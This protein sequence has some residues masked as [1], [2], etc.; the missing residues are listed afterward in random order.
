MS[1][2]GNTEARELNLIGKVELKIALVDSDEAL[3]AILKTYLPP[4]LLKLASDSVAV[5]NK[6]RLELLPAILKGLH[7]NYHES[8][9]HAATLFNLFLKLLHSISLPSRGDNE[10]SALRGR[11]GFSE[12]P[13]D[14]SFLADWSGKLVLFSPGKPPSTRGPGLTEDDYNFLQLY[15][16][17]DTWNPG[18]SDGMN[19]SETKVVCIRFVASGAFTDQERFLP[20]LFASA[21]TNSRISDVGNDMLKR[22]TSAISLEDMTLIRNLYNLYLGS[23]GTTGSLPARPALQTKILTFLSRSSAASSFVEDSTKI[24]QDGLAHEP[25]AQTNGNVQGSK[26]G[27]EISRLRGQI[28]AFTNWLARISSPRDIATFAPTLVSHLRTYIQDQG[29][30][31]PRTEGPLDAGELA[32]RSYGYESIGLLASACADTLLLEPSLELLRWLMTSLSEDSSGVEIS[33]SIENA[34]GSIIRAFGGRPILELQDSLAALFMH[35]MSLVPTVGDENSTGIVRSTK[36]VSLRFANR[37]LSYSNIDGRYID[38]LSLRGHDVDRSEV[39]EEGRKG[40]DPYWHRVLNPSQKQESVNSGAVQATDFPA[41]EPLVERLFGPDAEWDLSN[42][43]FIPAFFAALGYCRCVLLHQSLTQVES[44]PVI[45]TE[46]ARN[47][48]ALIS[49]NEDARRSLKTLFTSNLRDSVHFSRAVSIYLH[50]C[51]KALTSQSMTEAA[52]AG[53]YFIEI[54][55]FLPTSEYS[56]LSRHIMKLQGPMFSTDSALSRSSSLIFG[57]L[58]SSGKCEESTLQRMSGVFEQY[59]GSWKDAIGADVYKV[60]GSLLATAFLLSRCA[61]RNER[62]RAFDEQQKKLKLICFSVLSQSRDKMLLDAVFLAISELALYGVLSTDDISSIPVETI[63]K[64]FENGEKG[65]ERAITSLGHLAMQC[66]EE[67]SEDSTLQVIIDRL[68]ELHNVRQPEVQFAVGEA[69]SCAAI[70]WDSKAFISTLDLD[71]ALPP[72]AQHDSTLQALLDRILAECKSTKPAL[73]Q[74]TVIWLLCLVQFCG[75]RPAVQSRLQK[76]QAAFKGFLADRETL[77]QES[78]SRG[79]TLIYE[80]GNQDLK[81]DLIRDLVGS[82]TGTTSTLAGS[83]SEDTELFE[84]GA[85]P[86]GDGSVRTYKDIMSLASEVGDSSLVY[87]F[88]SLASHNAIWSSRAAFGRFGLSNILSDANTDG[89]FA[90]NPKL[91]PALYRYRFDPNSGVRNAMNDIWTAL[92]KD[93]V[94]TISTHFTAIIK[95]LMKSILNKEWRTRQASCA[96]IADLVQGRS[97]EMYEEYLNEIWSLAFKVCDDIKESVRAAAMSLSRV[98]VGILTRSLEARDSSSRSADKMLKQVLPFLLSTQGLESSAPD[99][100]DFSRKTILQIIKKSSGKILRPFV[101]ELVGRLLALLSS[102]EPEMINYVHMNAETFGLTK[103]ELDDARLKHIRGSS[104]LEA[105]ERCLDYLDDSS[106]PELQQRLESAIKT[107]IGLPS[108]VGCSRVLVS[109]STQQNFV[110][111]PYADY[112]LF[113]AQKQVFDRNDT[114]SSAYAISCGYLA[115]LASEGALLKLVES[116]RV[117]YFDTEEDRQRMISG[118]VTHAFSK[119]A[120]DRFNS[121]AGEILPFIFVAKH[122]LNDRAQGLFQDTWN[123]N[124]GGSRAVLLYLREI[125]Q[126]ASQHLDSTRWALKHTAAFSIAEVVTNAGSTIS[127][128]DARTIW[129]ALEK[130]LVGKTW[131][132]KEKVLRAFVAFV[133]HSTLARE[134]P[135]LMEQTTKIMLRESRRNNPVYHQ[136]ALGSLSDF[137]DSQHSAELYDQAY[138]I[139]MSTIEKLLGDSDEMDIDSSAGGPSSKTVRDLTIANALKTILRSPHPQDFT[140]SDWNKALR[141]CLSLLDR[142]NETERGNKAAQTAIYESLK[143]LFQRWQGAS[144]MLPSSPEEVYKGYT[145]HVFNAQDQVENVRLK[146]AEAAVELAPIALKGEGSKINFSDELKRARVAERSG[147]VQQV[148]ERVAKFSDVSKT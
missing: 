103:Q 4:L 97:L 110:F 120:T 9:K 82:F 93:P 87:R 111:K 11:F 47:I 90:N 115:R 58:A 92:V 144:E 148:L 142:V 137:V 29:W 27:L 8:P 46:W 64:F 48:D 66:R 74:A 81:T 56:D 145:R 124:V 12:K 18:V 104:M 42:P 119:Y 31:R 147:S 140:R 22:A 59:L 13:E 70:G 19:L 49:N 117:L 65:S 121:M 34:L 86:T 78:A 99:V 69:F 51:F 94:T 126:L 61:R 57:L 1:S 71:G 37:C 43:Q 100:Q 39:L 88:M 73:R 28:F 21:D 50:A 116:C 138:E 109:L 72:S 89:Y 44:P 32:S 26:K 25:Q 83:I 118:D 53:Q 14:A 62:I 20:A 143:L 108:K 35:H 107:V 24:I 75:H 112:F 7:A 101:P 136:D 95:D 134:D 5:R 10:D 127:D 68:H 15:G 6:E 122:D 36:F 16:K 63:A 67:E 84:A 96:A 146:A 91:Y 30:P 98:L 113:I 55:A 129:P 3:Q 114:I 125:V 77:N 52:Q 2:S 85:L 40:L 139:A 141:Q 132:G 23:G 123:E 41:F 45:D 33:M 38:I 76:C 131:E 135:K 102:I 130:A 60:Y 128:A 133:K 17:S 106:M 79:L 105:I 54:C 80:K